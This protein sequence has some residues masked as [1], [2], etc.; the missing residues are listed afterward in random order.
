MKYSEKETAVRKSVIKCI[1][2][3]SEQDRVIENSIKLCCNECQ[4]CN[5]ENEDRGFC[6]CNNT[7]YHPEYE[8]AICCCLELKFKENKTHN[9]CCTV[10][11]QVLIHCTYLTQQGNK[12]IKCKKFVDI[13]FLDCNHCSTLS[14][15]HN[16]ADTINYKLCTLGG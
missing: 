4:S 13:K 5:C 10:C 16:V 9:S 1:M 15:V 12:C 11:K 8:T 6:I 7:F 14:L 2:N 3:R